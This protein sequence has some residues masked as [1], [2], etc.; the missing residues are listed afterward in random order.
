MMIEAGKTRINDN[1][2]NHE[3]QKGIR[4]LKVVFHT[5]TLYFHITRGYK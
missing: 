3:E 5:F 2:P 1:K 4:W